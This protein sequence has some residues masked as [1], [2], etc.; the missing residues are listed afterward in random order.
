MSPRMLKELYDLIML[1]LTSEERANILI[2]ELQI[3]ILEKAVQPRDHYS[4]MR[5]T[6]FF[7]WLVSSIRTET[8]LWVKNSP[9][10]NNICKYFKLLKRKLEMVQDKAKAMGR[11][12]KMPPV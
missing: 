3:Y 8:K 9:T 1:S 7:N 12:T 4:G 6:A 5:F 11:D 2:Y 10:Y